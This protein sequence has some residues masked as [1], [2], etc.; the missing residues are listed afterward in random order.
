MGRALPLLLVL[1]CGRREPEPAPEPEITGAVIA[2][3]ATASPDAPSGVVSASRDTH[4]LPDLVREGAPALAR[5]LNPAAL[6]VIG[7]DAEGK[8]TC[9]EKGSE[10]NA[11]NEA[12]RDP[13]I[14]FRWKQ[15]ITHSFQDAVHQLSGPTQTNARVDLLAR[16]RV[17]RTFNVSASNQP[18]GCGSK[19]T[20][21]AQTHL[22]VDLTC[23]GDK[24]IARWAI[25]RAFLTGDCDA[26]ERRTRAIG[27]DLRCP[28]SRDDEH[29]EVADAG[30]LQI[31]L[32]TGEAETIDLQRAQ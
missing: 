6:D 31:D 25:W 8:V 12:C 11:P 22:T 7:I 27:P 20:V 14:A 23:V 26:G 24:A 17:V 30:I 10:P 18:K 28:M 4:P 19:G 9:R 16:N 5:V 2:S 13:R 29:A 3:D 1:A 15:S 21:L 32:S